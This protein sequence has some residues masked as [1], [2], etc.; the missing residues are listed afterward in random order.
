MSLTAL[1]EL[2]CAVCARLSRV[3]DLVSCPVNSLDLSILERPGE[4]VTR[5]ERSSRDEPIGEE[6]GPIL[7][8]DALRVVRDTLCMDVCA[9]C[10]KRVKKCLLPRH[11]LANGRWV[12]ACPEV[13]QN[14]TYVEQLLIAKFRHSFCVAQ[15]SMGQRYLSANVIVFGQPV[16]HAYSV[17]PPDSFPFWS[18]PIRERGSLS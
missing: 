17:L 7:F 8:D 1:A 3:V 10:L 14:L 6:P 2:P 11:A 16:A 5:T 18:A 4:G 13:L 15:V 12:G 9:Q